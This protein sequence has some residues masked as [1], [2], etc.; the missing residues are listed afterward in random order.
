MIELSIHHIKM[1]GKKICKRCN[2]KILIDEKGVCL[3]TFQGEKNL[4]K[5]YWHWQCYLDW[6]NES[7]ENRAKKIY[8]NT[9]KSIL[10]GFKKMLGG[11]MNNNEEETKENKIYKMGAI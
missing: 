9:M 3:H 7:L 1:K 5:V 6:R 8:A 2:K 4:E 11:I 10:P